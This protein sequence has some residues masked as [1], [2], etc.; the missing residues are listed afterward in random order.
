MSE[1]TLPSVLLNR[2]EIT[3]SAYRELLTLMFEE[4]HRTRQDKIVARRIDKQKVFDLLPNQENY[5]QE[6]ARLTRM[7]IR[8]I[9]DI[10]WELL[11]F[12]QS[13]ALVGECP[14]RNATEWLVNNN[15]HEELLNN[16]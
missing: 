8:E 7:L 11:E 14:D 9:D 1:L 13:Q 6:S 16:R 5:T 12:G 2:E 10:S 15:S 4:V 3:F